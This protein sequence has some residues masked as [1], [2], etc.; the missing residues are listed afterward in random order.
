[1]CGAEEC[2][3]DGTFGRHEN[4]GHR[5][6]RQSHDGAL[7]LKLCAREARGCSART[8]CFRSTRMVKSRSGLAPAL[9][10]GMR[11]KS[12]CSSPSGEFVVP[13]LMAAQD[14]L[15]AIPP[16]CCSITGKMENT[17][18]VQGRTVE[19]QAC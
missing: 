10:S 6:Q 9:R 1:M 16:A 19:R 12:S 8:M 17:T 14:W 11:S 15:P 3:L 18:G 5:S 13:E 4:S 7:I 2:V